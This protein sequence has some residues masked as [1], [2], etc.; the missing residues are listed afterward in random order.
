MSQAIGL[1]FYL[2][3]FAMVQTFL[4]HPSRCFP[5]FLKPYHMHS[6]K[7]LFYWPIT[8]IIEYIKLSLIFKFQQDKDVSFFSSSVHCYLLLYPSSCQKNVIFVE[9]NMNMHFSANLNVGSSMY[10][11]IEWL[12]CCLKHMSGQLNN[13]TERTE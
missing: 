7:I 13:G 5:L 9:I 2:N 10:I 8:L 12:M 11:V 4:L 6:L 3:I 1:N